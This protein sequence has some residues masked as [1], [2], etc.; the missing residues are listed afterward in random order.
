M[1]HL[2]ADRTPDCNTVTEST[3]EQVDY[4]LNEPV[5]PG[6]NEMAYEAI[7]EELQ[8][9]QVRLLTQLF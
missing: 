9:V 6:M 7:A 4:I 2:N 3:E 5:P 8:M 1:P